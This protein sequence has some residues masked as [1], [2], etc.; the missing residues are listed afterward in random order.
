MDPVLFAL[1][2]GW[3][4]ARGTFEDAAYAVRGKPS[5]R[6]AYRQKYGPT[7][8]ERIT[9]AAADR[10][11]Q[12]IANGPREKPI[13]A[14]RRKTRARRWARNLWSDA[15]RAARQGVHDFRA[16]RQT[17]TAPRAGQ[18]GGGTDTPHGV[19]GERRR[20]WQWPRPEPETPEDPPE[21]VQA[22]AER[23][24]P[25]NPA[26]DGVKLL[27]PGQDRTGQSTATSGET[28][29]V[30]DADVVDDSNVN[31]GQ[32]DGPSAHWAGVFRR[33][34]EEDEQNGHHDWAEMSRLDAAYAAGELSSDQ[35]KQAKERVRL[36]IRQRLD[37]EKQRQN[38]TSRR[39]DG[40]P[41]T[42]AD[43]RF[44]DLRESGYTGWINQDGYPVDDPHTYIAQRHAGALEP[45]WAHTDVRGPL[46]G[47][48]N[49]NTDTGGMHM[50]APAEHG[51]AAYQTYTTEMQTSC[52]DAVTS[53]ETTIASLQND[54][55]TGEA[56]EG[57]QEAM[58]HFQAAQQAIQ[59]S[60]AALDRANTVKD[61]YLAEQGAG[62]KAALMAE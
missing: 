29:E 1:L 47:T 32:D 15:T 40:L 26:E 17:R 30:I 6:Q 44:F 35:W 27:D 16:W 53:I 5:P 52:Q 10:I 49:P 58:E 39:F 61:A 9:R 34:A 28:G 18:P 51:L 42:E 14:P 13:R 41:E 43:R 55:F 46:Q 21:P 60:A 56:V 23:I 59:K 20:W 7:A 24:H 36:R 8:T 25:D 38:A 54:E 3:F 37:A 4:L 2:M 12:R 11:A 48:A 31:A 22:T 45:S 19:R 62:N 33:Q 57:L 50:S